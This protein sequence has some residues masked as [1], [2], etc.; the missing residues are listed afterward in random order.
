MVE[1]T[2]RMVYIIT[3][4]SCLHFLAAVLVDTIGN[5]LVRVL[6]RRPGHRSAHRTEET[7]A[8]R[9]AVESKVLHISNFLLESL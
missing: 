4:D 6:H 3:A 8:Q 9:E 7:V 1:Q 5:D 2:E